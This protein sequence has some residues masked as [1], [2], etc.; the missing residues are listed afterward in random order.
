MQYEKISLYRNKKVRL[1]GEVV[2]FDDYINS[3]RNRNVVYMVA[4]VSMGNNTRLA[5]KLYRPWQCQYGSI[6]RAIKKANEVIKNVQDKN[7]IDF[8]VN[9]SKKF[10]RFH[11]IEDVMSVEIVK[12]A[13]TKRGNDYYY[14]VVGGAYIIKI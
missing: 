3:F 4:V 14:A 2:S 5:R 13:M 10:G 7:M 6:D 1:N 8:G 9:A 11:G 12:G